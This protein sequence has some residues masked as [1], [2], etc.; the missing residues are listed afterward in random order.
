M[1]FGVQG[2]FGG[3]SSVTALNAPMILSRTACLCERGS[4]C[5]VN[6]LA[7]NEP[8][9]LYV[10]C[11]PD[12]CQVIDG[13]HALSVGIPHATARNRTPAVLPRWGAG[14]QELDRHHSSIGT[15]LNAL[16]HQA[17]SK[18][19]QLCCPGCR[20][21]LNLQDA[22]VKMKR[23]RMLRDL[24]AH[25]LRPPSDKIRFRKGLRP[26][27]RRQEVVEC[28]PNRHRV[29]ARTKRFRTLVTACFLFSF[30]AAK[31][32]TQ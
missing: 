32:R 1:N 20:I 11:S 17:R 2:V 12:I 7:K 3:E 6:N 16:R 4:S 31:S 29:A 23:N 19:P 26:G 13:S 15:S 5:S 24:L 28:I 14:V 18:R 22:S 8:S 21:T 9:S 27:K 30:Q 10:S 25:N